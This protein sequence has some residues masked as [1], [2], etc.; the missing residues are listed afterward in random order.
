VHREWQY[1]RL[2][3]NHNAIC[4]DYFHACGAVLF[5]APLPPLPQKILALC[6]LVLPEMILQAHTVHAWGSLMKIC[7]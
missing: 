3:M 5:D 7:F 6:R 4:D 1:E 2:F